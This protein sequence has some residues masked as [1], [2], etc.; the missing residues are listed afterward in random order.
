MKIKTLLFGAG[1]GSEQFIINE[2]E[3]RIFLAYIDNNEKR[4]NTKFNDLQIISPKDIEKYD[5]DEIV[6][7]T[8]WAREV[9]QQLLNEL[10][11]DTHKIVI[12]KKYLLKKPRP[13]QDINTKNLAKDIIK[14]FSKEA[15]KNNIPLCIDFGT[16]LGIVR[17]GDIILWDDD[18][19][20]AIDVSIIGTIEQWIINTTKKI[21]IKFLI[22]KQSDKNNRTTSYQIK[23]L[24]NLFND[25]IISITA[26]E[27]DKKNYSIHLPSLG[28][29]Y[30]PKKY[31]EQLE[32]IV[33]EDVEILVPSN[34]KEYLTFV[35]GDWKTPKKD[36]TMD[37][38]NH[39]NETSFK[40]IQNAN[41]TI[42]KVYND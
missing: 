39:I 14:V 27:N 19:D 32:I 18:I 33:W 34:Y 6:I 21:D 23:F 41:L 5:Y 28:K 30:A 20:F 15:I 26:R 16:L 10:K 3:S 25:F 22:E 7:T 11:I 1:E 37:D 9:K 38:Y 31:F 17:D 13:F 2:K 4:Y 8:Q 24:N 42:T 35:Y 36:I 29:W 40:D 12:P